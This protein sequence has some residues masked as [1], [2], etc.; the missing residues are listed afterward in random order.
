[1]SK[2]GPLSKVEKFYIEKNIDSDVETISK[3]LGRS[4]SIV[5]KYIENNCSK[6]DPRIIN[7]GN[8]MAKKEERGVTIM[9]ESA[10]AASDANK[11]F[12]KKSSPSWQE[13]IHK[14]KKEK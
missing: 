12:K 1:M 4:S 10:S 7:V 6:S 14:I 9:T 13:S 5:F 2:K 11:K 3:D 8:L